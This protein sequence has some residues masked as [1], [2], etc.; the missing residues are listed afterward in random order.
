MHRGRLVHGIK[1]G[2]R[3]PDAKPSMGVAP[4]FYC[5]HCV[6]YWLAMSVIGLAVPKPPSLVSA[7]I[8]ISCRN[9]TSG[10]NSISSST[11]MP[12]PPRARDRVTMAEAGPAPGRVTAGVGS[13]SRGAGTEPNSPDRSVRPTLRFGS[14]SLFITGNYRQITYW[15]RKIW[16]DCR[17]RMW[18]STTTASLETTGFLCGKR[19]N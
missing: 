13:V 17:A 2:S 12:R 11:F 9:T 1:A 6:M 15:L 18:L 5:L 14:E 10:L 19:G 8:S 4:L 7:G 3:E 16:A